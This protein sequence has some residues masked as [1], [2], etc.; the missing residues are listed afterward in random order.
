MGSI[1]FRLIT[2]YYGDQ[3][4]IEGYRMMSETGRKS[5]K[6]TGTFLRISIFLMVFGL[7]LCIAGRQASAESFDVR[8]KFL[9]QQNE[10]EKRLLEFKDSPEILRLK[11]QDLDRINKDRASSGAP[12]VQ[13]DILACRVGNKHCR[14]MAERG[15]TSHLNE[16]GEKPY[17]RY[18]FAGGVHHILENVF[19]ASSSA[20]Y[21]T[22]D[23]EGLLQDARKTFMAE[24]PG[25][26]GHRR[27]I[28][29]PSHTHLG[30]G[31]AMRGREFRYV[32][33]FMDK[34]IQ[35]DPFDPNVSPGGKIKIS[36]TIVPKDVGPYAVL[37]YGERIS[38]ESIDEL[39]KMGTYKDATS[40]RAISLWPWN[41]PFDR[42]KR[43]FALTLDFKGK[44]IAYYYVQI[45][46]KKGINKIPT[47]GG[48]A[49]LEGTFDA[50]GIVLSVGMPPIAAKPA[51]EFGSGKAPG[52]EKSEPPGKPG[53]TP[54]TTVSPA[55]QNTPAPTAG[56]TNPASPG[57]QVSPTPPT[58]V[59]SPQ[60]EHG[61]GVLMLL[62]ML[63][64]GLIILAGIP[65]V[66]RSVSSRKEPD[67]AEEPEKFDF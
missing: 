24:T 62:L 47:R 17:H 25:Y 12:P 22:G 18:A 28:L 66:L 35:F 4:A 36:G 52:Q 63:I 16:K 65:I 14:E 34:Y 6:E 31:M 20:P 23:I 46:L 50:S 7:G 58:G 5:I 27:N 57:V 43:T 38:P 15:Y 41:L 2:I 30:I 51:V 37:V 33:E 44:K 8:L 64:G 55:V 42:A 48:P 45:K 61:I 19:S 53:V 56:S 39:E 40:D 67:E 49:T 9:L 54:G 21:S 60:N 11:L 10:Q 3:D 59:K 26:D 29:D 32:Q 1:D 13:L